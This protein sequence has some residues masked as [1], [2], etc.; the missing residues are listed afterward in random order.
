MRRSIYRVDLVVLLAIAVLGAPKVVFGQGFTES[1]TSS[2]P[3]GWSFGLLGPGNPPGSG[4]FSITTGSPGYL[5]MQ[6]VGLE[7]GGAGAAFYLKA[8]TPF[9]EGTKIRSVLNPTNE[10]LSRN[11]GVITNYSSGLFGPQAYIATITYGGSGAL[12][13]TRFSGGTPTNLGAVPG[14]S[15]GWSATSSYILEFTATVD[16]SLKAQIFDPAAPLV[17]LA[18]LT[19]TDEFPFS[20][21]VAGLVVQRDALGQAL[22]GTYGETVATVPEPGSVMLAAGGLGLLGLG[23][24]RR[25]RAARSTTRS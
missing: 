3:A 2:S 15:Y 25:A 18:T 4:S 22:R 13:I 11:V 10:N 8:D 23:G 14:E 20:P 7:A 19:A 17:A 5:A 12:D 24:W 1:W 9:T 21:G 6:A 16:G